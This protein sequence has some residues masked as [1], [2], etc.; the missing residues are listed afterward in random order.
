LLAPTTGTSEGCARI[1]PDLAAA[2]Q[3]NP[4]EYYVNVHSQ[5]HI[6]GAVRGQLGR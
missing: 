1:A 5:A 6:A 3:A 2:I 4:S